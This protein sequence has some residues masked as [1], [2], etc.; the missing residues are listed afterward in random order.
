M[1]DPKSM[2]QYLPYGKNLVQ[3]DQADP[4]IISFDEGV[5]ADDPLK[6]RS[7]WTEVYQMYKQYSQVITDGPFKFRMAILQFISECQRYE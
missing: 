4:E 1:S 6:L 3:I 5:H 7:Y 2:I